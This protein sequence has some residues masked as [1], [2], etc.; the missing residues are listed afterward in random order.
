MAVSANSTATVEPVS[1]PV[2]VRRAAEASTKPVNSE[3]PD[4]NATRAG[5]QLCIRKP[6]RAA[7]STLSST[8]RSSITSAA[9]HTPTPN[10]VST[11][12][13]PAR[14]SAW[15]SPRK[16][17]ATQAIQA[18]AAIPA[19]GPISSYGTTQAAAR[20]VP[21]NR[22]GVFSRHT[23]AAVPSTATAAPAVSS[24][25]TP[26]PSGAVPVQPPAAATRQVLSTTA[27]PP[28]SGKGR[29]RLLRST[30]PS[31]SASTRSSAESRAARRRAVMAVVIP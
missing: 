7:A 3:P 10:A 15:S 17:A 31:R 16:A 18:T 19:T 5:C 12:T 1:Y 23:S 4:P 14:P 26:S 22:N 13:V 25:P 24:L 28:S 11:P 27:R 9:A 21:T 2:R 29:A 30:R 8:A 20:A 6:V